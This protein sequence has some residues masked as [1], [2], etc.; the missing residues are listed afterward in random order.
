MDD[1]DLVERNAELIDDELGERGLVALAV[2]V[3]AGVNPD[4]AG[5]IHRTL[6]HWYS[7]ARAPS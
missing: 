4:A 3:R 1:I 7:P 5:G 2:A 6:A